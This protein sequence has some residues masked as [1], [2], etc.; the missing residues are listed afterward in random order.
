MVWFS[1]NDHMQMG[2]FQGLLSE[3]NSRPKNSEKNI[4]AS[5]IRKG[6]NRR[7]GI[8]SSRHK[9]RDDNLNI[10]FY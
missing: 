3:Q 10:V 4:F 9:T 8:N 6:L 5:K 1:S 7:I 2:L